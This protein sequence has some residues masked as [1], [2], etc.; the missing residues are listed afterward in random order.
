[1]TVSNWHQRSIKLA[2]GQSSEP[3]QVGH[4]RALYDLWRKSQ[5]QTRELGEVSGQAIVVLLHRL[6]HPLDQPFECKAQPGAWEVEVRSLKDQG[7]V[8]LSITAKRQV[9]SEP[10]TP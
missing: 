3:P 10:S 2:T 8:T 9:K 1:M 5:R 6:G 7:L 4:I